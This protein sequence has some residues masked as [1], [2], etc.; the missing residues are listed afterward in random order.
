MSAIGEGRPRELKWFHAGPM[1]F[2][3]L[4]TSRLYVLGLSFHFTQHASLFHILFVNILLV[5]VGFCYLVI[6]RKYP[7]GGG[8]YS[9]A[10][11]TSRALALIGALMLC[12]DY[13]VTAALSCLDAFRYL[14]VSGT[15]LGIRV[16]LL[17][18]LSAI[19]AIGAVNWFGPRG[20]GRIALVIALATVVITMVIALCAIPNLHHTRIEFP[21]K[22]RYSLA[23]W[24]DAWVGFT[25][26]ILALSGIEAIANMTGIMVRPVRVT[27]RRSILPVLAEVVLLNLILGAAMNALP[28]AKL[29]DP[30]G[31]H[32]GTDD[33]MNVLATAYVGPA[34]SAVAAFVF[35]ALL[36]SAV[37]TA[38]TDLIAIQYMMA[39]DGEA[40]SILARLNK[41]GVPGYGLLTAML[42]P[43][44][45]LIIF[46]DLTQLAGLY[47]VGV[48]A[49]ITINL[50]STGL[51]RYF[52]LRSWERWLLCSVGTLMVCILITLLW[53]KPH[54]RAF[55]LAVLNVGLSARLLTLIGRAHLPGSSALATRLFAIGCFLG[56]MAITFLLPVESRFGTAA[57]AAI[58]GLLVWV[59]RGVFSRI[60]PVEE[61]V[62]L[63]D[64]DG[65]YDPKCRYLVCLNSPEGVSR[66]VFEDARN[67]SA[68]VTVLH[69]KRLASALM[70]TAGTHDMDHDPL[71]REIFT[72]SLDAAHH[73]GVPLKLTY[74]VSDSIV[75]AMLGEAHKEGVSRIYLGV[76]R[77][78][79]W[80]QLMEKNMVGAV[81]SRIGTEVELVMRS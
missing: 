70:G 10:R 76:P 74:A 16:E 27:A 72:K 36:L 11:H 29:I 40:P 56:Q 42:V 55:S 9:A 80:H 37:N 78:T 66:S 12:A 50:F 3:D 54:A 17:C 6:C 4:G 5:L 35:G 7:D 41:H 30:Q 58:A 38:L 63:T 2:G 81:A 61:P 67:N 15:L 69:V 47:S 51:T 68:G 8:V 13:T 32:L 23:A 1:L 43:A 79:T 24:G 22:A 31:H 62:H 77:T 28:D 60:P 44:L 64:F 49:A 25:E 34:F 33:M 73:L 65:D 52:D 45:L 19:A 75:E 26:I 46:T 48:V 59:G 20:M 53:N 57:A 14:G 39:R 71:A 21:V 18:T